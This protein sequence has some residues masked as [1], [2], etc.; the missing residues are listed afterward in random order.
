[1]TDPYQQVLQLLA[2]ARAIAET[3][4][5]TDVANGLS[6]ISSDVRWH[7]E[8]AGVDVASPALARE[9]RRNLASRLML[10]EAAA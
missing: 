8:Q 9:R 7:A 1:M 4:H 10:R 6:D 5:L 3:H 2:T